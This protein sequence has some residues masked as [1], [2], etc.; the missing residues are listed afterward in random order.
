MKNL[1]EIEELE[2]RLELQTDDCDP[3]QEDIDQFVEDNDPLW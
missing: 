3:T 2:T 1:F